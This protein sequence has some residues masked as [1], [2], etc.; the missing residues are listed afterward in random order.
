MGRPAPPPGRGAV[1]VVVPAGPRRVPPGPRP[2]VSGLGRRATPGGGGIGL[3]DSE[4]GGR[5]PGGG[6]MDRP[7]RADGGAA[8]GPP[9]AA[10]AG[11]AAPPEPSPVD[12][13]AV[14][15]VGADAAGA[16]GRG[17]AA[18]VDGRAAGAGATGAGAGRGGC[19]LPLERTKRLPGS[20]GAT[21]GGV[22]AGA[23]SVTAAAIDVGGRIVGCRRR[24]RGGLGDGRGLGHRGGGGRAG[25]GWVRGGR[26]GV[27]RFGLVGGGR[28]LLGGLGGLLGRLLVGLRRLLVAD[29]ALALRLA[30]DAIGLG[31]DHTRGVRLHAD[32]QGLTEV[33][34]LLVGHAELSCELIHADVSCQERS[35]PLLVRAPTWPRGAWRQ[36]LGCRIWSSAPERG[37]SSVARPRGQHEVR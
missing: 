4:V 13:G 23:G 7:P 35:Q 18:G 1:V 26:R 9:D 33:E 17:G 25:R 22:G 24:D 31:V 8:P 12:G 6:G 14:G 2:V 29:E 30:T 15:A 20:A 11:G 32:A 36:S 34:G 5:L 3:P 37:M 16:R 19:S 10:G 21:G 27:S 28:G